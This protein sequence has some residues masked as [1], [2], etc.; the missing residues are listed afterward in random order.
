[1]DVDKSCWT[2][3]VEAPIVY[4]EKVLNDIMDEEKRCW[5]L[6][7][8]EG[9]RGEREEEREGRVKNAQRNGEMMG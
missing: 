2:V 8:G 6:I 3:D 4:Q 9:E 7:V 5:L 1:M